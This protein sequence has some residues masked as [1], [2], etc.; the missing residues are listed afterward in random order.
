MIRV[1]SL[2]FIL[3]FAIYSS[4][5]PD[6]VTVVENYIKKVICAGQNQD[7]SPPDPMTAVKN[8]IKKVIRACQ[9]QDILIDGKVFVRIDASYPRDAFRDTVK[10]IHKMF[11]GLQIFTEWRHEFKGCEIDLKDIHIS[12]TQMNE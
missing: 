1:L 5:P 4:S 10:Y 12:W 2:F 11:A 9:N 8:Y 3:L 6:S 7:P